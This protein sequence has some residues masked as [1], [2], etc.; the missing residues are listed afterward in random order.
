MSSVEIIS[1]FHFSEEE[2]KDTFFWICWS[3][4]VH[5]VFISVQDV[6]WTY[7][8]GKSRLAQLCCYIHLSFIHH[9]S[10]QPSSIHKSIQCPSIRSSIH[11]SSIIFHLVFIH[12]FLL[13]ISIH[14]ITYP[15]IHPS[16]IHSLYNLSIHPF[17]HHPSSIVRLSNNPFIQYSTIRQSFIPPSIHPPTHP[18]SNH[19]HPS[20]YPC[21]GNHRGCWSLSP[22]SKAGFHHRNH[23]T[24]SEH[25]ELFWC[26]RV[27]DRSWEQWAWPRSPPSVNTARLNPPWMW[28][29]FETMSP[30]R[31][32]LMT[33]TSRLQRRNAQSVNKQAHTQCTKHMT[34]GWRHSPAAR[35]SGAAA[36]VFTY[37][38]SLSVW[39]L[40]VLAQGLSTQNCLT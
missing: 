8:C 39:L 29:R 7:Q 36:A 34:S 3:E 16:N 24:Q 14:Y 22:K 15:S 31:L 20:P 4:S 35:L 12:L 6:C 13:P 30:G 27:K 17:I 38:V 32:L 18:I 10:I 26:V 1:H 25:Q 40:C 11:H 9:L 19:I 21:T 33:S 23:V 37:P 5:C 2:M 28:S